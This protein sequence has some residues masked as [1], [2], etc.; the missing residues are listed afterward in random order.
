MSEYKST[1]WIELQAEDCTV[2][3]VDERQGEILSVQIKHSTLRRPLWFT[4]SRRGNFYWRDTGRGSDTFAE[5]YIIKG[6]L[7]GTVGAPRAY[8]ELAAA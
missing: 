5:G 7:D 4:I 3:K 2:L 8:P 1:Q 6:S